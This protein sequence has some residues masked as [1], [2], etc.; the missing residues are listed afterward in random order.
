MKNV[1]MQSGKFLVDSL[2]VKDVQV[3][4]QFLQVV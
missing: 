1:Y 3:K 4:K 2:N